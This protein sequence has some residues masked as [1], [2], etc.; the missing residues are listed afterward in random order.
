MATRWLVFCCQQILSPWLVEILQGQIGEHSCYNDYAHKEDDV[1]PNRCL[2]VK[3][4]PHISTCLNMQQ[5]SFSLQHLIREY[6]YT[7]KR[8]ERCITYL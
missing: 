8:D 2:N 4:V 7:K 5:N 1:S 3:V 6:N